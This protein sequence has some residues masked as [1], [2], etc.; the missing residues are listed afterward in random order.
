MAQ[1]LLS[2]FTPPGSSS[3]YKFRAGALFYGTTSNS[4]SAM[5]VSIPGVTEYYTGLTLI[6]KMGA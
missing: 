1:L 3:S 6:L 4:T 2:N 5:T